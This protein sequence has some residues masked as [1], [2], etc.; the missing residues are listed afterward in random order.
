MTPQELHHST[1]SD[2]RVLSSVSVEHFLFLVE[3]RSWALDEWLTVA[4]S[5]G[6][7]AP[8]AVVPRI[9]EAAISDKPRRERLVALA[10]VC[11]Q[12][13]A[14][15]NPEW[16]SLRRDADLQEDPWCRGTHRERLQWLNLTRTLDPVSA[17]ARLESTWDTES[18][19]HRAEFVAALESGAGPAD[20]HLL[21]RALDDPY[22]AV[23]DRAVQLL[24]RLPDSRY[25]RRMADRARTW[26]RVET[27]P[28]RRRL[29]I[30]IPGSLDSS[31]RRDGIEDVH[32]KNKGIRGWWLRMVVAATPLTVWEDMTGSATGA[33]EIPME[34]RWRSVMTEGWRGATVAQRNAGWAEAFLRRDGRKLNR[35][36]ASLVSPETLEKY[37]LSGAA[38]RYLLG[39]DGRA[40][41]D[42]L[43]HPWPLPVARKVVAELEKIAAHQAR[44]GTS[45]GVFSRQNHH[46][47]LRSAAT[48]FPFSA[49]GL[50]EDA[51]DRAVDG[52]WRHAFTDAA[53]AIDRRRLSLLELKSP[54]QNQLTLS[55]GTDPAT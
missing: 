17:V 16:A 42:G 8:D 48:H 10:G 46:T 43:P 54:G 19:E 33:L 39:V 3:S 29:V 40:L 11:G 51:A 18:A 35:R 26:I 23:R 21:E 15:Q 38:D 49:A 30:R 31:A 37:V 6:Y 36:I 24:R 20:E 12:Q 45:L 2:A 22:K 55:A 13:L 52:D 7:R 25:A 41:L 47:V 28:L 27:K 50:L 9:L 53:T 34:E 1:D 14:A 32:F 4:D 5:R 44:S